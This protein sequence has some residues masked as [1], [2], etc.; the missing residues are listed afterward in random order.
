MG[1]REGGVVRLLGHVQGGGF[2]VRSRAPAQAAL[3]VARLLDQVFQLTV[4]RVFC[5]HR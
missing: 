3:H 5:S 4:D 2:Q 1:T